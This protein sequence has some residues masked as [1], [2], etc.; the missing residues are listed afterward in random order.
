MKRTSPKQFQSWQTAD[1]LSSGVQD[2]RNHK[3][4]S[5]KKN[6]RNRHY[7]KLVINQRIRF[8]TEEE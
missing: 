7:V 2:K 3:R 5:A 8:G 1:E 6:R 4:A